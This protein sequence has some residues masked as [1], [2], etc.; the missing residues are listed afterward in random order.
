MHAQGQQKQDGMHVSGLRL[1]ISTCSYPHLYTRLLILKTRR[2]PGNYLP[3]QQAHGSAS[4]LET[5]RT[6]PSITCL[7]SG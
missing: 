7:R 3:P 2:R 1:C 6:C 4:F 5:K